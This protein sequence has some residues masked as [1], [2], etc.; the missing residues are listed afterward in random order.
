[1][2]AQHVLNNRI[3]LDV[4]SDKIKYWNKVAKEHLESGHFAQDF[5]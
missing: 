2:W 3:R 1:M 4:I 5:S